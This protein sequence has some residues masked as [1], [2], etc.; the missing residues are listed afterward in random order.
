[1]TQQPSTTNEQALLAHGSTLPSD[2]KCS[3]IVVI[4]AKAARVLRYCVALNLTLLQTGNQAEDK[5]GQDGLFSL[6]QECLKEHSRAVALSEH[7]G[8]FP[9][10]NVV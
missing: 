7:L 2:S 9:P 8:P 1:M 4:S 5:A 6:I 10:E 3:G